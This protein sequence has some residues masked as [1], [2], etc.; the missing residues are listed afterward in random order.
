MCPSG[1]LRD[2]IGNLS[3]HLLKGHHPIWPPKVQPEGPN[4][5]TCT[6]KTFNVLFARQIKLPWGA[7]APGGIHEWLWEGFSIAFVG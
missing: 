6:S 4:A 3:R 5:L 7:P 1:C 2:T